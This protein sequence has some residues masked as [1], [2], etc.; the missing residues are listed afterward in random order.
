MDKHE[1][2]HKIKKWVRQHTSFH[3]KKHGKTITNFF[4]KAPKEVEKFIIK[5]FIANGDLLLS[6]KSGGKEH[7]RRLNKDGK[8]I[9]EYQN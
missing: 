3:I 6:F 8:I 9:E 5:E 4:D 7:F 1:S 2:T